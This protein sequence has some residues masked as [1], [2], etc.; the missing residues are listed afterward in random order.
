MIYSLAHVA[1]YTDKFEETI[2]FYKNALDAKEIEY[3]KTDKNGCNLQIGSFVL[4]IF[5]V[6]EPLAEGCFRHIALACDNVESAFEKAIANGAKPHMNPK[7]VTL[8]SISRVAFVKGIND[9]Q[10]EFCELK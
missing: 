7:D 6:K 2:S 10:I 3:F 8:S 5:E 1:L 4:E 9:E